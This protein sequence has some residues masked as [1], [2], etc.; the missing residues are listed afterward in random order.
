MGSTV[1]VEPALPFA[2][3]SLAFGRSQ[4][5]AAGT[6]ET[7]EHRTVA[8]VHSRRVGTG[9]EE[10]DPRALVAA[11]RGVL[12]FG[13][14]ETPSQVLADAEEELDLSLLPLET[15]ASLTGALASG[16]SRD[17]AVKRHGLTVAGFEILA[18][19][20]AQRF[21]REPHLLEK[22]K[23]LARSSAAAGR[24]GESQR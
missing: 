24:R 11:D 4:S 14:L 18:R 16:E 21:K 13:R 15:Y 1:P 23:D 7:S 3:G 20:W 22:F 12:P 8:E 17:V 19:A 10:A 2:L 5:P 6:A 9:T